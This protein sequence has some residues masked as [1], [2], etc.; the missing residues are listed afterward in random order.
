MFQEWFVQAAKTISD[1]V[2]GLSAIAVASIGFIG[3]QQW[4]RELKGKSKFDLA[5]RIAL[6]AF[7]FRDRFHAARNIFTF[8]GESAD[9]TR[10]PDETHDVAAVLDEWHARA[11]RMEALRN[12]GRLLHEASWEVSVLLDE[13]IIGLFQPLEDTLRDLSVS[14]HTYF[15]SQLMNAN[16]SRPLDDNM[17]WLE[18]HHRRVYGSPEDEIAK[19]LDAAVERLA[20]RIKQYIR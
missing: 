17:A 5:R 16:R 3:L 6:N 15:Q 11:K 8:A 19:S 4:K 2:V 12:A 18:E 7:D 13:D 9:R 1:I 14:F 10:A 20:Q